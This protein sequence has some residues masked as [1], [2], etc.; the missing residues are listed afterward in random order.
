MKYGQLFDYYVLWVE[1]NRKT[2]PEYVDTQITWRQFGTF[3][4]WIQE[5]EEA[6]IKEFDEGM[7]K[8]PIGTLLKSIG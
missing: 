2:N 8:D 5:S 3:V 6:Q 4:R 1:H 7:K